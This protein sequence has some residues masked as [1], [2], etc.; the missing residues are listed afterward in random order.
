MSACDDASGDG[1]GSAGEG[2]QGGAS[3]AEEERCKDSCNQLKF[4]DCNDAADHAACF[5]ACE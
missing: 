4:F 2:G 3:A 1:T 5:L